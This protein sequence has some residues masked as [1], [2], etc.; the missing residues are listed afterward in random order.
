MSSFLAGDL[1]TVPCSQHRF[2]YRQ[3]ATKKCNDVQEP[4]SLGVA[5]VCRDLD[6]AKEGQKYALNARLPW[7]LYEKV[8]SA[9]N[10]Q[11]LDLT[12]AALQAFRTWL[13]DTP[14]A[15]DEIEMWC[16]RA[17][18][19]LADAHPGLMAKSVLSL[20]VIA[21][22]DANFPLPEEMNARLSALS[23]SYEETLAA[24]AARR[25]LLKD[26]KRKA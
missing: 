16:L 13:Q 11:S 2:V 23:R 3:T 21:D 12:G 19:A 24:R 20:S 8:R 5:T 6:M 18:R 26:R 25:A 17:L 14:A 7:D 22:E 15:R 9:A 1:K 4:T 10:T